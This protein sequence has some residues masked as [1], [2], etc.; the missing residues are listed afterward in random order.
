MVS[1]KIDGE[2]VAEDGEVDPVDG[3]EQPV[4]EVS[5]ADAVAGVFRGEVGEVSSEQRLAVGGGF[6]KGQAES[7][8]DGGGDEMGGVRDP[9]VESGGG[10]GGGGEALDNVELDGQLMAS[11]E[12]P[13]VVVDGKRVGIERRAADGE[14]GA[15]GREGGEENEFAEVFPADAADG[16]EEDGGGGVAEGARTRRGGGSGWG[17]GW[18]FPGGVRRR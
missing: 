5:G 7:F 3:D 10:S 1:L 16:G 13:P 18:R 6:E 15:G 17:G 12:F 14:P 4:V 11:G 9:R 2:V 8:G